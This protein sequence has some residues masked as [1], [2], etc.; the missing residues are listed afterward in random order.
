MAWCKTATFIGGR[1]VD[2]IRHAMFLWAPLALADSLVS[3]EDMHVV[4]VKDLAEEL[5]ENLSR[6]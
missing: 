3:I 1:E 5:E 4:Y 2:I 6:G